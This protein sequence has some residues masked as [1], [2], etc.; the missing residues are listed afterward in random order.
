MQSPLIR[1]ACIAAMLF[2]TAVAAEE[3]S[4]FDKPVQEKH[5]PLQPDPINPQ[6]KPK[7]SCFIYPGFMVKQIDRGEKGAEQLSILPL[8]SQSAPDCQEAGVPG[9]K[10][11]ER[12]DWAGYFKGVK[13]GH[14]FFDADD[15]VNGGL[16]FAVFS[17]SSG[18]KLLEDS[19]T[20][21]HTVTAT[22]GGL[23]L[24]YTRVFS[25]ECSLVAQGA[26]CWAHVKKATGL[27]AP[28][29]D[30]AASYA[31]AQAFYNTP[32]EQM[33]SDPSVI[34]Y[35]AEST[36]GDGAAKVVP[37]EGKVTCRPAE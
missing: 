26:E 31:K 22:P 29:P 37:V 8:G 13:G 1:S 3:V 19:T 14:V 21:L 33:A 2:P 24:R 17:G 20:E 32:A 30:C 10:A 28:Q 35:E 7:L 36:I 6:A 5:I 16:G 23:T 27:A 15:G 34:E 18:A 12:K 9:E 4:L 11:V 25:A